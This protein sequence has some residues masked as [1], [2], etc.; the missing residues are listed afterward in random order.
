MSLRCSLKGRAVVHINSSGGHQFIL[1]SWELYSAF[2]FCGHLESVTTHP[3]LC[4]SVAHSQPTLPTFLLWWSW[5]VVLQLWLR[6][7]HLLSIL[8]PPEPGWLLAAAKTLNKLLN[9]SVLLIPIWKM[10]KILLLTLQVCLEY[11]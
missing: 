1:G 11:Y 4:T 6:F 3:L 5:L 7:G 8:L 2:L 9:F 10:V